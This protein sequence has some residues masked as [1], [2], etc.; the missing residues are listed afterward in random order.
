MSETTPDTAPA[1]GASGPALSRLQ[2]AFEGAFLRAAGAA[3][4]AHKDDILRLARAV[5][6]ETCKRVGRILAT[7][8]HRVVVAEE[9]LT[10]ALA[11]VL[12]AGELDALRIQAWEL[13]GI[14]QEVADA[15]LGQ[16]F[17]IL[18]ETIAGFALGAVAGGTPDDLQGGAVVS[19]AAS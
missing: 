12:W 1:G 17:T 7:H 16:S 14:G 5:F 9:T 8:A 11:S 19:S 15:L 10:D 6:P 4:A 2:T 3:A 18:G 13:G